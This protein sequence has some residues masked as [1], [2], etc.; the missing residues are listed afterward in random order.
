MATVDVSVPSEVA[1][2]RAWQLASDLHRFGEWMTIFGG[3]R[4]PVPTL[5]PE[6]LGADVGAFADKWAATET[7]ATV[8]RYRADTQ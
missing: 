4:S 1:P 7:Y 5:W 6:P 3:W 8:P 2:Q